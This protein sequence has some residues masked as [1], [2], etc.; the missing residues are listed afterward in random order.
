MPASSERYFFTTRDLRAEIDDRPDIE[1][2]AG[3]DDEI[4]LRRGAQQPVEL[5]QR[6]MQIGD[7][8]TA[9]GKIQEQRLKIR[10][11]KISK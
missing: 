5:R 7:D 3:K 9:H 8:E 10:Q 11:R 2:I 4:E 1:R 6:I